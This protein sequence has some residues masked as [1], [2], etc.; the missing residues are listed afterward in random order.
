MI[1]PDEESFW[2]VLQAKGRHP[3]VA[4][5]EAA[6]AEAGISDKRAHYLA[7]KWTRHGWWDYGVSVRSGWFTGAPRPQV[8]RGTK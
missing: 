5:W 8:T 6:V 3:N 4:G 2:A 1:R 7:E